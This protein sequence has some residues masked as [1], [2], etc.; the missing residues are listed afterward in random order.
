MDFKV[1]YL[2]YKNKYL[3]LKK[4]VAGRRKGGHG[5]GRSPSPDRFGYEDED[6][7]GED[8]EAFERGASGYD[9]VGRRYD[10]RYEKRRLQRLCDENCSSKNFSLYKRKTVLECL[11]N[12][13]NGIVEPSFEADE[14][15]SDIINHIFTRKATDETYDEYKEYI[16]ECKRFSRR[17][18]N[19]M[20]EPLVNGITP[21][22][23]TL[24]SP[25]TSEKLINDI[26]DN[27]GSKLD[28]YGNDSRDG[29]SPLHHLAISDMPIGRLS[30]I[31]DKIL[32]RGI[33]INKQDRDGN[34]PLHF[35]L[36]CNKPEIAIL[37]IN[38]GADKGVPNIETDTPL[39]IATIKR[40]TDVIRA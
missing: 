21:F 31:I 9:F 36:F 26:F 38:K 35:A 29:I 20:N 19:I 39:M 4:Q 23:A 17:T 24:L 18:D 22:I 30:M 37:L 27:D 7:H 16:E 34:T 8:E 2:K 25:Y 32:E 1:K 13:S 6:E 11:Q 5:R 12:I 28:L 3:D 10:E 33:D 14:L 15:L 40:Y